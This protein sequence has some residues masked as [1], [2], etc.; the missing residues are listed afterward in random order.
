MA[1]KPLHSNEA[2]RNHGKP[3]EGAN[4]SPKIHT[5]YLL[6]F[7]SVHFLR[8][9]QYNFFMKVWVKY[10]LGIILGICAS[11]I[12]PSDNATVLAVLDGLKEFAFRFGRYTLLPLLFFGVSSAVFKLRDTK[13][14]KST[15]LWTICTILGSTLILALLGLLSILIVKLPRIPISGEK[16]TEIP[17]IDLKN[18]IMQFFPY[19]AFNSLKDGAFLLPCFIFAGFAGAGC[20]TDKVSSK[21][22]IAFFESASKLCYSI[23]SF[24]IEWFSVGMIAIS[25]YWMISCRSIFT[26]QTY[27]PLIIMLTVDFVIVFAVIYPLI[28]HFLCNHQHPHHAMYASI[29]SILTSF[30]TGDS[31]LSLLVNLRHERESLGAHSQVADV[32]V[33]LYSIFARGG[34]ALVNAICFIVILRSYSSLGFSAFDCLWIFGISIALSFVLGSLPVG[35]TFVAFTIMCTMYGRGFEAGYLLLRPMAPVLC[36]FAALFDAVSAIFG[37]Y[38]VAIKTKQFE[39]VDVKHFI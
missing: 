16:I 20:T 19:S 7:K 22:V 28:L 31:N 23:M 9:S 6:L 39:H 34:S 18:L 1:A 15:A 32:T 12:L 27:L 26:S 29:T 24:F 4:F 33:P 14:L 30:I 38:I 3:V 37:S 5:S 35:G 10:L 2:K 11:F 13:M 8:K 17:G 25:A 21:P 36:S